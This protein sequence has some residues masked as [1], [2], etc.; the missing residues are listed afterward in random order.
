M[1]NPADHMP[2][3]IYTCG[4]YLR[5]RGY[6]GPWADSE[7][8]SDA[9]YGLVNACNYYNADKGFA[10]AT[11]AVTAMRHEIHKGYR[12]RNRDFVTDPLDI[13]AKELLFPPRQEE[14]EEADWEVWVLEQLTPELNL[15]NEFERSVIFGRANDI[16]TV[17]LAE[18]HQCSRQ[19]INQTEF[20]V[21]AQLRELLLEKG[22]I[23]EEDLSTK[24]QIQIRDQAVS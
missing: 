19:W 9:C 2:L 7:E 16:T 13:E 6:R 17:V 5:R 4:P 24:M 10:F 15:L 22:I 12:K 3:V 11:Y 21:H 18:H 1:E 23:C 14:I 8:Y 20:R